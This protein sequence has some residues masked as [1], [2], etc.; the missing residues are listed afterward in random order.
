MSE[1]P[2]C[3]KC[4]S[5]FTYEDGESLVCPE[6]GHEWQVGVSD[7]QPDQRVDQSR[8]RILPDLGNVRHH[9]CGTGQLELCHPGEVG[10]PG[11]CVHRCVCGL[12]VDLPLRQR[13]TH[14]RQREH[15][16]NDVGQVVDEVDT[17]TLDLLVEARAD[18]LVDDRHPA[19]HGGG[20]QVRV[21]RRAVHPVFGFVHLQHAAADH[22]AG[23]AARD[24]DAGVALADV[25]DVVV[26][27]DV[28]AARE[29]EDLLAAG[30]HPVPA[31]GVRP[32]HR[33]PVVQ[34]RG[35]LVEPVAVIGGVPV[36]VEV[37]FGVRI[38]HGFTVGARRAPHTRIGPRAR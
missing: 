13:H 11:R 2:S 34:I 18:D 4:R 29:V 36:E 25:R 12:A 20:G 30:G 35:D 31:V 5:A 38:T 37:M 16:G 32:R 24:A 14:Q 9:V 17:S 8:P 19:L 7:A 3:P 6:C 21:Q 26:V 1:L 27:G 33:A 22:G 23:L 10:R 28:G 15:R